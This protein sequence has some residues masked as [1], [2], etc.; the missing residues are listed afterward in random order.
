MSASASS[1]PPNTTP[2]STFQS[3]LFSKL[4]WLMFFR[5]LLATS[6]F[7]SAVVVQIRDN[8]GYSSL[9]YTLIIAIY[10]FSAVYAGAITRVKNLVW[11]AYVQFFF[12]ALFITPL[13]YVTG[14]HESIFSFLYFLTIISAS[15]LLFTPGA[16]FAATLSGFCYAALI[17]L[18]AVGI[19]PNYASSTFPE[20]SSVFYTIT[21]NV[22]GKVLEA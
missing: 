15:Y 14:G 10:L 13:I 9:L 6:L 7:G 22:S 16:F 8:R 1:L 17:G 19:I 2:A 3:S 21:I 4:K 20:T 12:D 5:L 11:F 18:L